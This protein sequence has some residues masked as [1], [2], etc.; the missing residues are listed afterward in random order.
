MNDFHMHLQN[1]ERMKNL[2]ALLGKQNEEN[3]RRIGSAGEDQSL[4]TI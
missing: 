4:S 1:K 2:M 3:L